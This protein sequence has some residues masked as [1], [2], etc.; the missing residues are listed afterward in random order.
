MI[1]G[2]W[3][4]QRMAFSSSEGQ[5]TEQ[6]WQNLIT[7]AFQQEGHQEIFKPINKQ[8]NDRKITAVAGDSRGAEHFSSNSCLKL[9][10]QLLTDFSVSSPAASCY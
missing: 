6:S 3:F 8:E 1:D 4:L 10:Q 7:W 9:T 5:E 2:N